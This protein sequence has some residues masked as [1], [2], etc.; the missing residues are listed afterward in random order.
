MIVLSQ[1]RP[2]EDVACSSAERPST[3]YWYVV[4][5]QLLHTMCPAQC[6]CWLL[7]CACCLGSNCLIGTSDDFLCLSPCAASTKSHDTYK[8]FFSTFIS[9]SVP[10]RVGGTINTAFTFH[11]HRLRAPSLGVAGAT[12][13]VFF[14][15]QRIIV[16]N[17]VIIAFR[18][19]HERR[20]GHVGK[21]LLAS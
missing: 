2:C 21:L 10:R 20:S 4:T 16:Y 11:I 3:R 1:N 6:S 5:P 14:S 17:T 7:C 8:Y 18:A 9:R 19:I 12:F 15:W 13:R